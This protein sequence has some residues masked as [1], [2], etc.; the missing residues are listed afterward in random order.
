MCSPGEIA[1]GLS[2][3][4]RLAHRAVD[5]CRMRREYAEF[6]EERELAEKLRIR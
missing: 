1:S 6:V 5:A 4:E 2:M 3:L